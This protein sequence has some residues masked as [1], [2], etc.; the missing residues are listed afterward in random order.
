MKMLSGLIKKSLACI[1][2]VL[3]LSGCSSKTVVYDHFVDGDYSYL[4]E[5]SSDLLKKKTD[6]DIGMF[7]V[8][9]KDF[10]VQIS[11]IEVDLKNN[12]AKFEISHNTGTVFLYEAQTDWVYSAIDNSYYTRV[13]F[14]E[15]DGKGLVGV[16][17]DY[18]HYYERIDFGVLSVD[19]QNKSGI[20]YQLIMPAEEFEGKKEKTTISFLI[21]TDELK[22]NGYCFKDYNALVTL[23]TTG[24]VKKIEVPKTK[25]IENS[26]Q[27]KIKT[28]EN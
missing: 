15:S 25:R 11:K 5:Y 16:I 2:L 7:S 27:L 13:N 4:I 21:H 10:N 9:D 3:I 6:S 12:L 17:F 1:T 28:I 8:N 20:S 26:K 24:K 23:G 22:G 14:D 18:W 19:N